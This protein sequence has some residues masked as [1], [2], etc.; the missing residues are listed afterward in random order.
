MPSISAGLRPLH[1]HKIDKSGDSGITLLRNQE[2]L[3]LDDILIMHQSQQKI[4]EIFIWVLTLLRNLGFLILHTAS[5]F[6]RSPTEQSSTKLHSTLPQ[7]WCNSKGRFLRSLE[8][9]KSL[10]S[11]TNCSDLKDFTKKETR[12]SNRTTD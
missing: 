3:Y 4:V 6:I 7:S 12:Q 2:V 10:H 1:L 5:G 11:F 8:K 9:V